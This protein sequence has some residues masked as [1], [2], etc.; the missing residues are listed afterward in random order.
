MVSGVSTFGVMRPGVEVLGGATDG[1]P[2]W[3]GV[4]GGVAAVG[5]VGG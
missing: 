2:G 5:G 4:G 3:R 1:D